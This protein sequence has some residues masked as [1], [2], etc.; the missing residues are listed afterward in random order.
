MSKFPVTRVPGRLPPESIRARIGIALAL[1]AL[2]LTV[3]GAATARAATV[4]L[5]TAD[6]FSVLGGSA[7][8]NTGPTVLSGDLGVG[9]GSA[10]TGFPPGIVGGAV[11]QNDA[12]AIQAQAD[13]TT[14]YDDAAG[15]SSTASVA[16]DLAGSTL[17]PGVYSSA[18]SLGLSGDLTL[19]AGGDPDAVFVFQ[20]GSTLTAASGSR[21]LL[22]GGAQACNVFWQVGS[23]ATIGSASAFTGNVLALTSISLTTGATLDGRALARNGAVTL[24]TNVISRSTCTPPAAPE[25]PDGP[26]P[27]DETG[28]A[29]TTLDATAPNA[30]APAPVGGAPAVAVPAAAPGPVTSPTR[31]PL[32]VTTGRAS[33]V[34]DRARL[35]G[36]VRPG[37]ANATHYFQY[38]RTT[39][40]GQRTRL[41]RSTASA[42]RR[43]VLG[44]SRELQPCTTYHYRV[45]G[46]RPDGRKIYGIDRTFRTDGCDSTRS[47]ARPPRTPQGFAG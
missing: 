22:I 4:G 44:R 41:D 11:H 20:A 47:P 21:V 6:G 9:P 18:S 26:G 43:T 34:G 33:L 7:V 32:L 12:V 37:S 28:I 17:V 31:S 3:V 1:V 39:R 35:G 23:S 14:A 2:L 29:G 27:G 25:G 16:G 24:D 15:R 10:I 8:T 30:P 38:G 19:D 13:L 45:V 5:G 46:V 42:K 36:T 40:Y